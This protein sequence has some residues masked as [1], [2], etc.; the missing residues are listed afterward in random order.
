MGLRAF[1]DMCLVTQYAH[2]G[3]KTNVK[4]RPSSNKQLL[5]Y[6]NVERKNLF[7]VHVILFR[8]DFARI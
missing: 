4:L 8:R 6:V 3:V 7:T 1:W 5:A 2:Y